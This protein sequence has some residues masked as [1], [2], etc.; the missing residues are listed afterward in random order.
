M[1]SNLCSLYL[2]AQFSNHN[3]KLVN[4]FSLQR[5]VAYSSVEDRTLPPTELNYI[6]VWCNV[7]QDIVGSLLLPSVA[8]RSQVDKTHRN[9]LINHF[10]FASRN[11]ISF[12]LATGSSAWQQLSFLFVLTKRLSA[13]K[14]RPVTFFGDF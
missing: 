12:W 3:L 14:W 4:I 8:I 5:V 1:E 7:F 10:F 11:F 9:K 6:I 13:E 2:I